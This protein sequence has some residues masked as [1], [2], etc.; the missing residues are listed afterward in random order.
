M[1]GEAPQLARPLQLAERAGVA[2]EAVGHD[3]ARVA[4]V[5]PAERPAEEP[6][7]RLLVSFGAEQE[8]DPRV[9]RWTQRRSVTWSTA[10]PRSASIRARSR[11]LMG[12]CRDQRTA[13]R[14]TAAGQR[15]P[16]NIRA[17]AMNGARGSEVGGS[18]A[19]PR[20]RRSAQ[21]NRSAGTAGTAVSGRAAAAALSM[22]MK[23]AALELGPHRA[24]RGRF[25]ALS[26]RVGPPALRPEAGVGRSARA[27]PRST[28]R[29]PPP[30]PP[31]RAPSAGPDG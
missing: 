6:P 25:Q 3:G 29:T 5:L 1:P 23:V 9:R 24:R 12:N 17:V 27:A 19:P 26:A 31:G 14:M 21:R 8:V 28:R 16:W 11:E 18:A 15:Q 22:T 20:S 2:R 10:T 30:A 13:Q 4:G 7:R